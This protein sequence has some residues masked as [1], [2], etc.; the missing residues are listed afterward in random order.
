LEF[1][2]LDPLGRSE[3]VPRFEI[4]SDKTRRRVPRFTVHL[5]VVIY[6]AEQDP[7]TGKFTYSSPF[8]GHCES[9]SKTG[10]TLSFIGA[11]V[12][13]E[14]VSRAGRLL[15]VNLDLPNGPVDAVVAV[16]R[17]ERESTEP[18][19][20]KR[21][22]GVSIKNISEKDAACLATYLEKCTERE[23]VLALK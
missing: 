23:P 1:K 16:V 11:R 18:G 6:L 13:D 20:T 5:P 4:D 2:G 17:H 15:F 3:R 22:I 19:K 10:L 8:F 7:D 9:I 14:D 12:C 21:I